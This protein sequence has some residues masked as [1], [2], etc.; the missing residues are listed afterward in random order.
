MDVWILDKN[1]HKVGIID[2]FKSFLWVDKYND[3]G[4]CELYIPVTKYL[5]DLLLM[6]AYIKRSDRD[7]PCVIR[8]KE[9]KTDVQNGDFLIVEGKSGTSFLDQRIVWDTTTINGSL[10]AGLLNMVDTALGSTA[11]SDRQ[12]KRANNTRLFYVESP[13]LTTVNVNE[14]ISY[15]N[16]GAVVRDR[17]ALNN[18]GYRVRLNNDRLNFGFYKGTDRSSTVI[19]ATKYDNL[20]SSDYKE[21]LKN[22]RNITLVAGEGEGAARRKVTVGSGSGTERYELFTDAKDLSRTITYGELTTA[23]PNGTIAPD[24]QMQHYYYIALPSTEII[25]EVYSNNPASSDEVT[26]SLNYYDSYLR[27]RGNDALAEHT[28]VKYFDASIAMNANFKYNTN[29]FLGDIVRI[30]NQYGI[31]AKARITEVVEA[32][33]RNGYSIEPKL[34]YISD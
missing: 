30:E 27:A 25:A 3:V 18:W 15:K 13:A 6:G 21:D 5:F 34:E 1:L 4:E 32:W 17:C 7:N 26:L 24:G 19:F 14:Q 11:T 33:D 28:E 20:K 31:G 22:Y 10:E 12:L 23:Y 9:M 8:K 29:Y 16:L 2:A